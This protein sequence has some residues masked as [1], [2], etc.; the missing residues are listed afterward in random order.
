MGLQFGDVK[1]RPKKPKATAHKSGKLGF[2]GDAADV[3]NISGEEV[4][5]VAYDEE[6]GPAGD[7]Y[8]VDADNVDCP[9]ES[10]IQVSKAGGYYYLNMRRFFDR[11]GVD[12]ENLKIIYDIE[13]IDSSYGPTYWLRRR[14]E[15]R[16][17]G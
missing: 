11:T 12:Y 17:R 3:M 7:L 5:C 8:L 16:S 2:N 13:E 10:R 1:T 15:P 14:E 9:D 6:E 4:F